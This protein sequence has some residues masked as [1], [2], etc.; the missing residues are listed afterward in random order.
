MENNEIVEI[1]AIKPRSHKSIVFASIGLGLMC[2]SM[3]LCATIILAVFGFLVGIPGTVF[4]ILGLI[5]GIT[6]KRKPAIILASFGLGW[7]ALA[8]TVFI[9]Y[10]LF[11]A[12]G[13]IA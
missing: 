13:L 6:D 11:L 1:E 12:A 10:I 3:F 5:F 8:I 4:S 7:I 2:F 9:V